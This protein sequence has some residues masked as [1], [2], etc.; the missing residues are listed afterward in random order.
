MFQNGVISYVVDDDVCIV[1]YEKN[2]VIDN[3]Q[4]NIIVSEKERLIRS[5]NIKRFIGVI[6]SSVKI[7]PETMKKFTTKS[8][9]NGVEVIGVVYVADKKAVEKIYKAGVKVLNLLVRALLKTPRL[10]F[11]NDEKTAINW[12]KSL[13]L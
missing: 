6:H 8:A 9:L 7:K 13:D 12:A 5:R 1:T 11:F 4:S 2:A 10:R 3:E